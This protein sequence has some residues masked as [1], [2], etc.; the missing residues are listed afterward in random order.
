MDGHQ[1]PGQ[2][3]K[4]MG[5]RYQ[6][7]KTNGWAS[8]T[9]T[10]KQMDGHQIPGHENK[11]LGIRYQDKKTNGW[12]SDTRTRK[13]MAGHQIPEQENKWLA[14]R[15]RRRTLVNLKLDWYPQTYIHTLSADISF[16][17]G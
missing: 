8:D 9:R 2:E 10:R 15:R 6:D 16:Y 7:M 13:Q 1:I 5:I 11:W 14:N 3:N 12:A 4:W 17:Y